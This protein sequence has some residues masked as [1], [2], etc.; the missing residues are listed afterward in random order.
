MFRRRNARLS[1]RYGVE[2]INNER[3]RKQTFS[4][5]LDVF[6]YFFFLAETEKLKR[7][8]KVKNN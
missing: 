7:K 1:E 8:L 2:A 3:R 6:Y 5:F 4:N